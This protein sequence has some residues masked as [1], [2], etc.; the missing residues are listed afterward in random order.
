VGERLSSCE[1]RWVG[2]VICHP[3]RPPERGRKYDELCKIIRG[4]ETKGVENRQKQEKRRAIKLKEEAIGDND[5]FF[6]AYCNML[7]LNMI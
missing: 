4:V 7:L 5:F 3:E 2:V 6:C 1:C